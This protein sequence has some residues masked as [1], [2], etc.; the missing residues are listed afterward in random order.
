MNDEVTAFW[1]DFLRETGRPAN[2]A[3][4]EVFHFCMTEELANSLLQL[5]LTGKKTAT[6]SS[7]PLYEAAGQRQPKLGDLSVVTDW[8]GTPHCVIETTAVCEMPFREMTFEICKRE[9]EDDTLESWQQ[10]HALFFTEEGE[11]MGYGF[12]PDMPIIFEDFEIVYRR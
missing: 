12:S 4:Y 9:G 6:T 2:I 3:P 8:G 7:L 10:G 5:V 1:Q 11:Q